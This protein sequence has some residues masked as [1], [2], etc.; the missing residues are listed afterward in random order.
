MSK[1]NESMA[2]VPSDDQV[3]P[4]S[5][6]ACSPQK[7]AAVEAR[8]AG[9]VGRG[10]EERGCGEAGGHDP[11][12]IIPASTLATS[13]TPPVAQTEEISLKKVS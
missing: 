6:E 4:D 8:A 12:P 11:K 5:S 2:A 10:E 1:K 9:E 7:V 3:T 13:Q